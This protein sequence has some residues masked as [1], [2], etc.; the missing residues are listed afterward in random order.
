MRYVVV[1]VVKGEAGDFNN[2]LRKDIFNKFKAK[3]LQ[4]TWHPVLL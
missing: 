1:S 3:S 2:K 4:I